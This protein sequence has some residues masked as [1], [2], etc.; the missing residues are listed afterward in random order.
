MKAL[1]LIGFMYLRRRPIAVLT[2]ILASVSMLSTA[3]TMTL[4][5]FYRCYTAYLGEGEDIIALYDRGSSTP[6]TG[7]IP[8]RLAGELRSIDGVSAFSM[9]ILAPSIVD[10]EPIIVRGVY[11]EDFLKLNHLDILD[12]SI[13]GFDEPTYALIGFRAASRLKVKPGAR[14][15]A[16]GV[17]SDRYVE[18]NVR[19]VYSSNTALDDEIIVSI[20]AGR[21]LRNAGYEYVT[22]IRVKIDKAK[23]TLDK[24]IE[25]LSSKIGVEGKLD[26]TKPPKLI[27][28]Y[29]YISTVSGLIGV[30]GIERFMERY[31][32]SYGLTRWSITLLS[33][34][35]ILFTS[36]TI[37]AAFSMVVER[38][39]IELSILRSLGLSRRYLKIDILL[40]LV[41][42]ILLS[43]LVGFTLALAL[44]EALRSYGLLRI[45]SYTVSIGLDPIILSVSIAS[46]ILLAVVS[47][48]WRDIG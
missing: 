1:R 31:L 19:T 25:D 7:L 5:G 2:V 39:R 14:L 6:F 29:N 3:I 42:Y 40:K 38:H 16:L 33:I 43:S 8:S 23:L 45:L 36:L 32:E 30:S 9:E 24:L 28:T 11:L 41:P 20:D 34:S 10:G 12:G 21:W 46:T 22:L 44:V 18:L 27:P 13:E 35:T 17:L 47:I 26:D 37:I 15:I 4:Q 48:A